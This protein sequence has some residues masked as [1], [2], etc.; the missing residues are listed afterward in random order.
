MCKLP[1]LACFALV[2]ALLSTAGGVLTAQTTT[3]TSATAT[4]T[5]SAPAT[6]TSASS[7]AQE[8]RAL[9]DEGVRAILGDNVEEG[10]A[11]I[12]Q[13]FK[14]APQDPQIA[15]TAKA[16]A[17]Y[18]KLEKQSQA[19]R[20]AEYDAAVAQVQRSMMAQ[21]H[22]PTLAKSGLDKKLRDKVTELGT[23]YRET[24]LA[25]SFA[26]ADTE[27]SVKMKGNAVKNLALAQKHL[28]DALALIAGDSSEYG[29]TFRELAGVLQPRLDSYKALWIKLDPKD[30]M[31][32]AVLADDLLVMEDSLNDALGD[33]QTLTDKQP[34]YVGLLYAR[35]AKQLAIDTDKMTE[36]A[37]Y[38]DITADAE[39]RAKAAVKKNDWT[40][41]YSIYA[42]LYEIDQDNKQYL[43]DS[44]IAAG[45]SRVLALYG[46]ATVEDIEEVQV[47]PNARATSKPAT[48]TSLPA[49]ERVTWK[50]LT[51]G[52]DAEMV[53]TAISKLDEKYVTK[54]DYRKIA[55]GGL[56]AVRVLAETPQA[57]RSFPLLAKKPQR[58]AF[59]ADLQ[60]LATNIDK[61]DTVDYL[62]LQLTWNNILRAN[63]RSVQIPVGALAM[64]FTDGF[65]QEMDRFS[66][67]IWPHDFPDFQ[68]QTMGKFYG[69]GIQIAKDK[70]EPLKVVSPLPGSPA[71]KAGIKT[72]DMVLSVNGTDTR[73]MNL[74]KLVGMIMGEAGTKVVLNVKRRGID[75]PFNVDVIRGQISIRTVRGW[76]Y[77]PD[78]KYDYVLDGQN[79]IAYMRISQFTETTIEEMNVVLETLKDQDIRSLIMDLRDNPGGLLRS[80]AAVTDEYIDKGM[81]VSTRGLQQPR[82]QELR[83]SSG[84]NYLQGD[85]VVLVNRNSASAAEIVSGALKDWKRSVTVGERS[86]GKGSVQE[87]LSIP[88]HLA[89]LKLTTARYYLP[90]GRCLHRENGS[91]IWGVDPDVGVMLTPKQI[92]RLIEIRRKT[93]L[94]QEGDA[95]QAQQLLDLEKQYKA[96][97]QLNTAVMILKVMQLRNGD[98]V[99]AAK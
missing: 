64:E 14:L 30:E 57:S 7:P 86:Y 68:K 73:S 92:R 9:A 42:L 39:A 76:R 10:I 46:G 90:S 60:R 29:K 94:L 93:D 62:D 78:G 21:K 4:A 26:D 79:K 66:N 70:G 27:Q 56:T 54:P 36:Q 23:A 52:I 11:L 75:K 38:K 16:L 19:E 51:S 84:G 12:Q 33:L 47:D 59:V 82:G 35:L 45:H 69:I 91:K 96:D 50:E 37:W 77:L 95:E 20:Q 53:R 49:E 6:T 41:A 1:R 85:L 8:A 88:R 61:K 17:D 2:L 3:Q 40:E 72:G 24:P 28:T 71:H 34:A 55:H 81:I 89:F 22:L 13:A 97:F 15:A 87:V 43:A 83:A 48:T 67:M 44:K 32:R 5:A 74:D 63:D 18:L 98:T 31:A 25:L 58:D 65:L 99:T 80:A